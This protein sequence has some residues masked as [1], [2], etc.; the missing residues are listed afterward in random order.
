ME[1]IA[2]LLLAPFLFSDGSTAGSEQKM[3][4]QTMSQSAVVRVERL[5]TQTVFHPP[6]NQQLTLTVLLSQGPVGS[7]SAVSNMEGRSPAGFD[8]GKIEIVVSAP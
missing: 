7:A 4:E 6:A 5:A 8:D 2:L 1:F 3:I